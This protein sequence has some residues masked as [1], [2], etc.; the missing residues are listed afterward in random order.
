MRT[1]SPTSTIW[2]MI[3]RYDWA[4]FSLRS[5]RSTY[6]YRITKEFV[7]AAQVKLEDMRANRERMHRWNASGNG[8]N[9]QKTSSSILFPLVQWLTTHIFFIS[10]FCLPRFRLQR[11]NY[12]VTLIRLRLNEVRFVCILQSWKLCSCHRQVFGHYQNIYRRWDNFYGDVLTLKLRM[13]TG[14]CMNFSM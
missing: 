8:D 4:T 11:S 7:Y 14:A 2:D 5:A 12:S 10:T 6:S 3:V 13:P 9:V 1:V